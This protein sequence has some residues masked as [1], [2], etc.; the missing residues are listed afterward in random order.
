MAKGMFSPRFRPLILTCATLAVI[1]FL[2]LS[3]YQGMPLEPV[4][5]T[6]LKE[7]DLKNER[8]I[9]ALGEMAA[10]Q[11]TSIGLVMAKTRREDVTWVLEYCRKYNTTPFVYTTDTVPEPHLLLPLAQRGREVSAYLSYLVQFYDALPPYSIFVHANEKQ[12]HN[13]LFGPKTSAAVRNLRLEAVDALGYVNLRCDHVP[14][15][16]TH[17]HPHD[18]SKVDIENKDIRAAFAGVYQHLFA[19]EN[20]RDVPQHIG[21]VCCAQF[22]VSR[23]RIRQRPRT[24]Y[25]RMLHWANSTDLT[26]SFGVGWVFET[27]WHVVFGMDDIYCP[28]YEQCRCDVYGWC[29]P[30]ESGMTLSAVHK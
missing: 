15:C 30:L 14:G 26:D 18:P 20:L 1:I 11:S 13:D 6:D 23:A 17:V 21:G 24:D 19:V 25:E 2:T 29:G 27:I 16:P 4:G 3:T 10:T 22:A 12:W 28:S 8:T 9:R 7:A 5:T